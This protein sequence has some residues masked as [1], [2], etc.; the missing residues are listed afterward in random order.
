[1]R[2]IFLKKRSTKESNLVGEK[3]KKG[4]KTPCLFFFSAHLK[5]TIL[6]M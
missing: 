5:R 4:G 2:E 1:M 3:R 6:N